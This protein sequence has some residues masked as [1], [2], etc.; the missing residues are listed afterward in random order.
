MNSCGAYRV[1]VYGNTSDSVAT[2]MLHV[3]SSLDRLR[4]NEHNRVATSLMTSSTSHA[5]ALSSSPLVAWCPPAI[6]A[7]IQAYSRY[8]VLFIAG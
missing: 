2:C 4:H 5:L 3:Q 7:I 1:I 8:P 6:I